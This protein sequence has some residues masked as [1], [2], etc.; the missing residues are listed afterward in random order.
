VPPPESKCHDVVT[1]DEEVTVLVVPSVLAQLMAQ[2]SVELDHEAV[3]LIDRVPVDD[4][5]LRPLASLTVRT[6]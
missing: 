5:V 3:S 1:S 2:A 4:S 6:R